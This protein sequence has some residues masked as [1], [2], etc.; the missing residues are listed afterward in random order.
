MVLMNL[1]AAWSTQGPGRA[2][3]LAAVLVV[4]A[5]R[6]ATFGFFIPTMLRLQ[7]AASSAE[8]AVR[9][10]FARWTRLNWLRNLATLVAWLAVLKALS[11]R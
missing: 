4:L 3:W 5:E 7:R 1:V 9:A 11:L 10:G 6:A 2:W 8:T